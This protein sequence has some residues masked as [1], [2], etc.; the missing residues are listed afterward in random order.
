LYRIHSLLRDADGHSIS[1]T[2]VQHKLRIVMCD[3]A[4]LLMKEG[5]RG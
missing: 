3:E 5:R 1:W 4:G 2:Y